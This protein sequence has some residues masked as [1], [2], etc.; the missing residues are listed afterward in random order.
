MSGTYTLNN[1]KLKRLLVTKFLG[2]SDKNI[3]PLNLVNFSSTYDKSRRINKITE[4]LFEL[5]EE[6]NEKTITDDGF[7]FEPEV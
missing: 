1:S 7:G 3:A 6:S 4:S 2:K 5:I